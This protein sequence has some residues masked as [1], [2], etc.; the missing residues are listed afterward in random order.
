MNIDLKEKVFIPIY[1]SRETNCIVFFEAVNNKFYYERLDA[2]SR[3]M[4]LIKHIK[5]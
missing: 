5:N 3:E 4:G 2:E 1:I